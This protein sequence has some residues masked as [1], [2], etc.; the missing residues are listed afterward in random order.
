MR[1]P[2]AIAGL[3]AACLLGA[4][5]GEDK[6]EKQDEKPDA[7]AIERGRKLF[8][9]T[10]DD[11]YPACADC[12]NTLPEADEAKLAKHLGPGVTL[13]GAA[14]RA[15]WRNSAD[16]EDVAAASVY[17]AKTWQERKSGLKAAQR[18]DLLAYL[19]SIGGDKALP[20]RKVERKPKLLGDIEGG[21]KEK[22]EKIAIRYC[23]GCHREDGL[24]FALE[25]A[26]KKKDLVARKVRGYDAKRRFH[27]QK[28]TMSYY[29]TDRL[30]DGEL[31]DII[32]YLGK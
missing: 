21:D 4:A 1:V 18:G 22:G 12:H 11:D 31:R 9:D 29:T 23:G 16:F 28:S 6:Q 10:Q 7:A 5:W 14:R 15:G 3:L 25:P 17:C 27:P 32:A 2:I 24:S 30:T 13:F 8:L 19:R 26:K 20:A